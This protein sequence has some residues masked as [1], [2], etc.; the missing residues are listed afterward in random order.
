MLH[1]AMKAFYPSKPPCIFLHVDTTWKFKEMIKFR[2]KRMKDLG[3][4]IKVYINKQ[5]L[6]ENINPFN[7]G[8]AHTDIMKTQ[9]LKQVLNELKCDLIF[10][11]AR[12]DE[13]K[14]RSKERIFSFRTREHG[15]EPKNQRPELWSLYNAR[16][17]MRVLEFFLVKWT[18]ADIWEYI[19]K[20]N[21]LIPDLY[22]SKNVQ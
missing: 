7:N 13:K 4:N 11:G 18:E 14:S 6:K 3:L 1:L 5:G 9:A 17:K 21:S 8:T 20:E 10:G 16:V 19:L 15:W 22:L 12:R 2:D